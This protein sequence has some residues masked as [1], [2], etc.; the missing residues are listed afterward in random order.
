MFL[1][2]VILANELLWFLH[3]ILGINY[4]SSIVPTTCFVFLFL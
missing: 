1:A 3:V 4:Y 2:P